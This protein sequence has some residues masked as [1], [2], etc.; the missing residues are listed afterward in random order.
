MTAII[1]LVVILIG[2]YI[3]ILEKF[4]N[5]K[6]IPVILTEGPEIMNLK[7]IPYELDLTKPFPITWKNYK[8][9]T[10]Q[11]TITNIC[12]MYIVWGNEFEN[13]PLSDGRTFSIKE[14]ECI[15]VDPRVTIKEGNKY[16]AY[17]INPYPPYSAFKDTRI[18]VSENIA[19]GK[20]VLGAIIASIP[21]EWMDKRKK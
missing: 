19:D 13:K 3:L 8:A 12:K 17:L 15:I 7:E 1:I 21:A 9:L 20:E 16:E 18:E 6:W 11:E 4:K 14:G 5:I 10:N 2:T